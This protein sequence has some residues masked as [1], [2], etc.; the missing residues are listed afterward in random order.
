MT[1]KKN[2]AFCIK[3][4]GD[5]PPPE[6]DPSLNTQACEAE[7]KRREAR[8]ALEDLRRDREANADLQDYG[9]RI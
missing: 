8:R 3:W 6:R 2:Q 9:V 1:G 5:S 7:R 4:R